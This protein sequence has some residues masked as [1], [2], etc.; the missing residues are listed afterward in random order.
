MVAPLSFYIILNIYWNA[1]KSVN[2]RQMVAE[3]I[4]YVKWKYFKFVG[5]LNYLK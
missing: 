2:K 5:D 4:F 1:Y 3:E